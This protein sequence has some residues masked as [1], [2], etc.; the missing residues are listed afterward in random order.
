M[1]DQ[2]PFELR[3]A[4]AG[5][6][7]RAR[8]GV[9]R[10]RVQIDELKQ[11]YEAANRRHAEELKAKDAEIALLIA[12]RDEANAIIWRYGFGNAALEI[13]AL[14]AQLAEARR[15]LKERS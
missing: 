4:D 2:Q 10:L 11:D 9:A 8:D 13:A 3:M 6:V 14:R 5:A 7:E 1:S 12:H 15:D